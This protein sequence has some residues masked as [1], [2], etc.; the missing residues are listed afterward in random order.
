[1]RMNYRSR[2]ED[3]RPR[4][5]E[6]IK[7]WLGTACYYHYL[8]QLSQEVTLIPTWGLWRGPPGQRGTAAALPD[9]RRG[10]PW[11]VDAG[12]KPGFSEVWFFQ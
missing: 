6:R 10:A 7:N 8:R 3:E 4:I 2:F 9:E 5:P 1:M 12:H 11:K